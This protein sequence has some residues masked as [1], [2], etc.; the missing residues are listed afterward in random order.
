[1]GIETRV[2]DDSRSVLGLGSDVEAEWVKSGGKSPESRQDHI[3]E[4]E[5]TALVFFGLEAIR[6]CEGPN[7]DQEKRI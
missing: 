6:I 5:E 2:V 3:W 1:M 7:T 4:A